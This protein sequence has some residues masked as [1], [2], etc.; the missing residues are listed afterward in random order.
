MK[1]D[2]QS[3]HGVQTLWTFGLECI[4]QF[5]NNHKNTIVMNSKELVSLDMLSLKEVNGG[6]QQ[7]YEAGLWAGEVIR[8]WAIVCGI[9][10]LFL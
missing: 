2:M 8:K 1:L 9:I 6:N 5:L 10:A 3:V 4:R 7:S